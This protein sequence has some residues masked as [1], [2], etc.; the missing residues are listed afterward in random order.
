[1]NTILYVDGDAV[2][3]RTFEATFGKAY[4]VVTAGTHHAAVWSTKEEHPALVVICL[5]P[6]GASLDGLECAKALEGRARVVLASAH[7][8]QYQEQELVDA[9]A[10]E[11]IA[12]PV[13]QRSLEIALARLS[14]R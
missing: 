12:L 3:R 6:K 2:G 13:A 1:M 14:M 5:G 4:R 8:T 10:E 11:F 9:P 7:A